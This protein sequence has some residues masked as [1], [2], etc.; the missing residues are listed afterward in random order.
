MKLEQAMAALD[1]GGWTKTYYPRWG[2]A[3][4][5][6]YVS[7]VRD[8]APYWGKLGEALRV[9]YTTRYDK[10]CHG[11]IQ[12]SWADRAKSANVWVSTPSDDGRQAAIV[13]VYDERGKPVR[14]MGIQA[15]W[16]P[17]PMTNDEIYRWARMYSPQGRQEA[18]QRAR[19]HDLEMERR[20]LARIEEQARWARLREDAE[21]LLAERGFEPSVIRRGSRETDVVIDLETFLSILRAPRVG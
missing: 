10:A 5:H 1:D 20:I 21:E 14:S 8:G 7:S 4:A 18:A 2:D 6:R 15:G 11:Y 16:D 19:E 17:H 12:V 3:R 13:I 9:K